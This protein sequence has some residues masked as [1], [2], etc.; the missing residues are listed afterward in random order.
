MDLQAYSRRLL[1]VMILVTSFSSLYGQKIYLREA[2]RNPFERTI[3]MDRLGDTFRYKAFY[4]GPICPERDIL[5]EFSVDE[6][7][8]KA[9]NSKTGSYYKMLPKGSY[10]M[11][12]VSATIEK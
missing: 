10:T 6:S 4:M 3:F 1:F 12:L 2:L 7:K 5:V 9:F 8:V 11:G